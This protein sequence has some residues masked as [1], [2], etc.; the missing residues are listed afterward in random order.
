MPTTVTESWSQ[1]RLSYSA[2]WTATRQFDVVGA[3]SDSAALSASGIP[4]ANDAHPASFLLRCSGP[5]IVERPGVQF[6]R[7][8]CEYIIPSGGTVSQPTPNPLEAPPMVLWE[9][10]EVNEMKDHDVRGKPIYNAAGDFIGP[11]DVPRSMY[12]LTITRNEP[13]F[14]ILKSHQFS[15]TVNSSRVT[16]GRSGRN[17]ITVDAFAMRCVA[18][19]PAGEFPA[20]A[21]EYVP[22]RYTFE[23]IL[24]DVPEFTVQK[25]FDFRILNAGRNG[26]YADGSGDTE[27]KSKLVERVNDATTQSSPVDYDVPLG[28]TGKPGNNYPRVNVGKVD[29]DGKIVG[30]APADAPVNVRG[31]PEDWESGPNGTT[32]FYYQRFRREDHNLIGL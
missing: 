15:N 16:L 25:P 11:I 13:Y 18:I 20:I 19:A 10:I 12:R 21:A 2:P 32:F 24:G 31:Q 27:V 29:Q 7:V 14:D 6:H 28:M 9:L 8:E 26:W 22:M 17:I 4:Q 5:R 3:L 30:Y 23:L 1:S